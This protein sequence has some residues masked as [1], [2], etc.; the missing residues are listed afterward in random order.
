LKLIA[1]QRLFMPKNKTSSL[2]TKLVVA[3]MVIIFFLIGLNYLTISLMSTEIRGEIVSYNSA[4]LERTAGNYEQHF[5]LVRKTMMSFYINEN[6][7]QFGKRENFI[8]YPAIQEELK[9]LVGNSLLMME[10]V[11]L[12]SG[13]DEQVLD[14]KKST[15]AD[16]MFSVFLKQET[17]TKEFWVRQYT[18]DYSYKVLADAT[19]YEQAYVN[20]PATSYVY[21]PVVY[22]GYADSPFY[23]VGLLDSEKMFNQLQISVHDNLIIM[24]N[25]QILYENMAEHRIP[26]SNLNFAANKGFRIDDD[27]YYFYEQGKGTGFTYVSIVPVE[28]ISAQLKIKSALLTVLILSIFIA[29]LSAVWFVRK[30]NNPLKQIIESLLNQNKKMPE[31]SRIKEFDAISEQFR[32]LSDAKEQADHELKSQKSLLQNFAYVNKMKDIWP[33]NELEVHFSDAPYLLIMFHLTIRHTFGDMI[34]EHREKNESRW[35]SYVKEYIDLTISH[36]HRQPISFHMEKNQLMTIVFCESAEEVAPVLEK[37]KTTLDID[38]SYGFAT[39][40]VSS[41]YSHSDELTE[42]Y[43]E[44]LLR[45]Q[46]RPLQAATIIMKD[47]SLDKRVQ[48]TVSADQLREIASQLSAGN[49]A[50]VRHAMNKLFGK[51]RE[52][53]YPAT[54]A[55]K[56]AKLLMDRTIHLYN[57]GTG[58]LTVDHPFSHAQAESMIENCLSYEELESCLMS[59]FLQLHEQTE[60]LKQQVG[61]DKI[62]DFATQYVVDNYSKAFNLEDV[63]GELKITSGYLSTYFKEKTG[64]NFVDYVNQIRIEKA[65]EMLRGTELKARE[66]AELAGYQNINSFN[67][68][69]KKYTGMT[70]TEYRHQPR[71]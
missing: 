17:Y 40:S 71:S 31:S 25:D 18:E 34:T 53:Q 10:D 51:L 61:T 63:A 32:H 58:L 62:I 41:I 48:P 46:M 9:R 38:Q 52:R 55:I 1:I 11:F 12:Y 30:I 27:Y 2:F 14:Y 42:A 6:I 20:A 7:Q 43:E 70:P 13:T 28:T 66:I 69:F 50:N 36:D 57:Q 22:K 59:F 33:R 39:I 45:L 35:Y 24:N 60:Q 26:D 64:T 29:I 65:C 54:E 49:F 5:E 56:L 8:K 19:F 47:D 16:Q 15:V 37:I 21:L 44:T 67:R 4:N 68:M 3:F 23:M